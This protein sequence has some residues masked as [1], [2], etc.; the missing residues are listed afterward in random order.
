MVQRSLLK[1]D[2]KAILLNQWSEA[3]V[4]Y[5]PSQIILTIDGKSYSE[6]LPENFVAQDNEN[7][8]LIG[9]SLDARIDNVSFGS[10]TNTQTPSQALV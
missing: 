10:N 7:R 1:T 8:L 6:V 3:S 4:T 9:N 5:T 2:L